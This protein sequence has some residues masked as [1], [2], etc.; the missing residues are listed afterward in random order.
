[1]KRISPGR[2]GPALLTLSLILLIP[3]CRPTPEPPY[4][5]FAD[6]DQPEY[7]PIADSGNA[8]DS[9]VIAA[10]DAA[11]VSQEFSLEPAMK[12]AVRAK[13]MAK[14]GPAL[15]RVIR[16]SA[17]PNN[18]EFQPSDPFLPRPTHSGFNAIGHGLAFRIQAAGES[19]SVASAVEPTL[20]AHRLA[21]ALAQGDCQ[22]AL[23]GF[24]I[25]AQARSACA[26]LLPRMDAG[27]LERLGNGLLDCY[28]SDPE[29]TLKNERESMLAGVQFVQ[30]LYKGR[31]FEVLEQAMYKQAQAGV[32]HLEA[33]KSADRVEYFRGFAAEADFWLQ[34]ARHRIAQP[35]AEREDFVFP[36][37]ER[38]WKQFTPHLFGSV[39]TYIPAR[40]RHTARSRLFALSCLAYAAGKSTGR[41]PIKFKSVDPEHLIDPY[42]HQPLMYRVAGRE[43]R[44]YSVGLD[45]R[46]DAG[47]S[48]AEG[49]A[50][51]LIV[52][53]PRN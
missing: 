48:D 18:T 51:D 31:D 22:D 7:T 24:W 47:E 41:A 3:G 29:I 40:D 23:L 50:P 42:T 43:F 21:R 32:E 25:A 39:E 19:G 28:D 17:K 20:A 33:L 11:K 38:P 4:E 10:R 1:M 5:K 2:I 8:W 34:S 14:I 13:F 53:P 9:F 46:D 15:D 6:L 52:D 16:G 36:T 26:P 35:A 12:P 30:D 45:G 27:S 37:G 49:L 44:I